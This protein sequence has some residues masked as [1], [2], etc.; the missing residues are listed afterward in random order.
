VKPDPVARIADA[1][2]YGGYIL[3]PYRR[4]APKDEHRLR[5]GG[6]FPPAHGDGQPGERS[7]MRSEVLL[8]G[9]RHTTVE[10]TVR[11]LQM[12]DRAVAR[13]GRA[14]LERVPQLVVGHERY[15]AWE[16]A[17]EREVRLPGRSVEGLHERTVAPIAIAGGSEHEDL[18]GEVSRPAGVLIRSWQALRG[19]VEVSAH[20]AAE[21]VFRVAVRVRNTTPSWAASRRQALAVTFCST[22]VLLHA[23][24][25]AFVSLADPPGH[26]R[27]A[28]QGCRNEGAWPVLVGDPGERATLLCS[29]VVLDDHPRFAPEDPPDLPGGGEIDELLLLHFLS[30]TDEEKAEMRATDPRAREILERAESMTPEELMRC[31][32]PFASSGSRAERPPGP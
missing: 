15:M 26:L 13:R 19:E 18:E 3:W 24:G 30:L 17:A 1:V 14:G 31:T 10:V 27:A 22:H 12:V 20:A 4:T 11:F 23:R 8:E 2:L 7:A 9:D 32:A 25:G 21:G 16:E 29:P 28:A 6:L 5:P